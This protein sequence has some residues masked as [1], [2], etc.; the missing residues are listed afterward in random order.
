MY[1]ME[2]ENRR[3]EA[4]IKRRKVRLEACAKESELL[5]SS[6]TSVAKSKLYRT[7]IGTVRRCRM[8]L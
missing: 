4:E 3:L 1:A 7:G 6:E 8:H 2:A 5:A